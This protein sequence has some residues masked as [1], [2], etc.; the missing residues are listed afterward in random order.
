MISVSETE[1]RA[2]RESLAYAP[3]PLGA[4]VLT[5]PDR[6]EFLQ[7][8]LTADV[9]AL[10]PGAWTPAYLLTPRGR[11]V[12]DLAV[13]DRETDLLLLMRPEVR[14][15]VSLG[16]SKS[17][18]LSES[19]LEDVG[20]R[21]QAVALTGPRAAKAL[22]DVAGCAKVGEDWFC[23]TRLWGPAW[24]WIGGPGAAGRLPVARDHEARR[25]ETNVLELLRVE[26]GVA[27]VGVD[28]DAETFPL[29]LGS[30][31]GISFEKGCY[32]GQETT[33]KM[34]HLG[35]S[36]R[37]LAVVA[38]EGSVD[39]GTELR[40]AGERVGRVTS[41]V[42]LPGRGILGLALLKSAAAA[43]GTRLSAGSG[44]VPAVVR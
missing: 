30:E 31:E 20:A 8:L 34:K 6:R 10:K 38:L 33:A 27:A 21:T 22:H 37:R 2:A 18:I 13:Y 41:V 29:E 5:G 24:L 1:Y 11:L 39:E 35:H 43:A 4:L 7:G 19:K 42:Q 26:A 23:R 25:V 40:L 17:I 12:G 14:A 44:D 32:M 16:L 28:T 9:A 15:A 3:V 36:N